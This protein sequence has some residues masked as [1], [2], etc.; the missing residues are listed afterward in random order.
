MLN[1][2]T[3]EPVP[4]QFEEAAALN[5][6]VFSD[7]YKR[8]R[9]LAL[10]LFEWE[11]LPE[12]MNERFLEQCLYWYGKAAI[13]NDDNLGIINTK[14]TPSE[15]LN[16]Y[17]ES[18]EYHCY[19][20]GY[21]ADFPLDDMVYVRNNLEALPTD[22]TIQLFAQRLYEAERT[23]DVNIKAQKTPVIILCDEK[24]RLTMKNIYMKYDGNEPVIYGK[25]G[26]DIDDIK[27]L[28]TD[29]PFVAD[30]LEE[31]KRNVW[32]EALSFLG[33]NN[34]MTEK[35]ERLVT[36]EVDANNQMIDLSAQTMLLTRELA[37]D[38][39][40]KLWPGRN[41]SVRQRSYQEIIKRLG[42]GDNGS[43][44]NGAEE[45]D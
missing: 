45:T 37:A 23:I 32:S 19:S 11:N 36:G 7:Y 20:T 9:L 21:D 34:V 12:S 17:G 3:L 42:G 40:N 24:Q 13:V 41:I 33:I 25:K 8:L 15:S 39:F 30:K 29:A 18:T 10:S 28:R 26:L 38:K 1:P 14:C 35:K 5:M 43:L 16:I 27:V 22:A 2:I 6:A 31:Y 44:Y 4:T